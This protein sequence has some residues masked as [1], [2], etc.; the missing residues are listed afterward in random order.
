MIMV[1]LML[2]NLMSAFNWDLPAGMKKEDINQPERSTWY[3][4]AQMICSVSR[5]HQI[6]RSR[7]GR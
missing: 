4:C 6:W 3:Y 1:E 7:D 5:G 2:A